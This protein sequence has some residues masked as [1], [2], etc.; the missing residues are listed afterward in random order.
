MCVYVLKTCKCVFPYAM[1]S[2]Q[3]PGSHMTVAWNSTKT[4][5]TFIGAWCEQ[6]AGAISADISIACSSTA[7]S[8]REMDSIRKG[9]NC[10]WSCQAGHVCLLVG[11]L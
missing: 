5:F 11:Y 8:Y 4:L 1:K 6:D 9:V 7:I 3:L 2:K 10:S